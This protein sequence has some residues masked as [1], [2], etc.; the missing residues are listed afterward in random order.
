MTVVDLASMFLTLIK[1]IK[2]SLSCLFLIIGIEFALRGELDD[3]G[4]STVT[5]SDRGVAALQQF[6]SSH[7]LEKSLKAKIRKKI[8]TRKELQKLKVEMDELRRR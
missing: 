6:C 1:R 2:S 8:T 7:H 5:S 4:V 3:G